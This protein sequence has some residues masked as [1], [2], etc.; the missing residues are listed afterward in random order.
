M[1]YKLN[2]IKEAMGFRLRE[3]GG[4]DPAYTLVREYAL[5][6]NS[7]GIGG[8]LPDIATC[9]A[10]DIYKSAQRKWGRDSSEYTVDGLIEMG[11][12]HSKLYAMYDPQTGQPIPPPRES[13]CDC[14]EYSSGGCPK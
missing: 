6:K 5:S 7:T 11:I 2:N 4:D 1:D 12:Y 14:L 13:L 9:K 3:S 10:V 8:L